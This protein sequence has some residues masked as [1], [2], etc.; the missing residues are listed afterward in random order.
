[1]LRIDMKRISCKN[2]N[3]SYNGK[4]SPRTK[5]MNLFIYDVCPSSCV[6]GASL[7]NI[8]ASLCFYRLCHAACACAMHNKEKCVSERNRVTKWL[9]GGDKVKNSFDQHLYIYTTAIVGMP[10]GRDRRYDNILYLVSF[11]FFVSLMLLH[12][13][14]TH[15]VSKRLNHEII[16]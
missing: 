2:K 1:M 7:A 4:K 10:F 3:K 15:R 9:T 6:L 12:T 5:W 13:Q 16:M 14:H 11:I 8:Y